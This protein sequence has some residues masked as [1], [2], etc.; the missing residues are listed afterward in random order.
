[1]KTSLPLCLCITLAGSILLQRNCKATITYPK[2]PEGGGQIVAGHLDPQFLKFL[3]VSRVSDLTIAEPYRGYF[4]GLTN[5]AS[6]HLLSAAKPG[7]WIYLLL[8]GTNAAGAMEL[9]PDKSG[10]KLSFAGLYKSDFSNETRQAMR[11]AEHLPKVQ[12]QRYELRRLDCPSILFVAVWLHAKSDDIII[13]LP[14]TFGRWE[15]YH[16]YSER[17]I[18][19]LLTSEAEKRLKEPRAYD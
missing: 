2:A 3:G 10:T 1:M 5:L 4:V 18:F 6:G 11:R 17:Q 7:G 15:A 19:K 8:R 14:P 9:M 16:P 13:P 12:A